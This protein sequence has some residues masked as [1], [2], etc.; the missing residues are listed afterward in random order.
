MASSDLVV[1]EM[2]PTD[3]EA[4]ALMA[5]LDRELGARY[6]GDE[7]H[8]I[9]AAN[10]RAVGGVFLIGR[11]DGVAVACGALRPMEDGAVEVKRMYV[12]DG[13]RGRK[14]GRAILDA[15]E[16][17]AYQRGYRTLRL[18]TGERQPEAIALYAGAG[19]RLIPCYGA[20]E[21]DPRSR[22]F[23]KMLAIRQIR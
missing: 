9:D 19:Y 18:E 14:F 3:P 22:C 12:R 10:F 15:L 20:H 7:I 13:Y 5:S 21:T 6:P 11:C 1:E 17:V 23:E 16:Q 4:V 2:D 8:G